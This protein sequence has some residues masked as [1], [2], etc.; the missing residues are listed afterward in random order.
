MELLDIRDE[1]GQVTGMQIERG[2]PLK[3]GQ[4]LLAVHVYLYNGACEFLIQKRS[5][6]KKQYPGADGISRAGPLCRARAAHRQP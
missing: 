5:R 4:Y 2:R 6:L 1:N 3:D